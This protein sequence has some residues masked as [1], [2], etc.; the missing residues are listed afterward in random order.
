MAL[1]LLRRSLERSRPRDSIVPKLHA[2]I[3]ACLRKLQKPHEALEACRA[4]RAQ[5]PDDEL[6]FHEALIFRELGDLA[7]AEAALLDLLTTSP[8]DR[9][10]NGDAGLRG[11]K[12]RH[13]LALIYEEKGRAAKAETHWRAAITENPQFTPAW[14]GLGEFY[15]KQS[16]WADVEA[17]A[18]GLS[19]C[20]AGVE[21]SATLRARAEKSRGTPCVHL[22]AP[23][24][25]LHDCQ[26]RRKVAWRV[27]RIG[28]RPRR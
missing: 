8:S 25:A 18:L 3:V 9:L 2:M 7:G 20:S 27:P 26:G 21:H 13:Q 1:P 11:Y 12:A 15:L 6:L 4:G 23:R 10:I 5:L 16:R 22:K 14:L 17:A 24:L 28:R 19:A